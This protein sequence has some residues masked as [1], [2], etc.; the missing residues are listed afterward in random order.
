MMDMT[1]F[2]PK[3]TYRS[4][5]EQSM[6]HIAAGTC[7]LKL[8]KLQKRRGAWNVRLYWSY[9]QGFIINNNFIHC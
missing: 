8:E 6:G 4:V 5:D 2:D 1:T 3:R 9:G 7:I